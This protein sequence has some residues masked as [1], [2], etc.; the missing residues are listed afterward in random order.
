MRSTAGSP[1]FFYSGIAVS[2]SETK[3]RMPSAHDMPTG[4]TTHRKMFPPHPVR[5]LDFYM[6]STFG[7]SQAINQASRLLIFPK[8]IY[9]SA[10]SSTNWGAGDG[11]RDANNTSGLD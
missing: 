9:V 5:V 3:D 4:T 1:F 8:R 6:Y 11:S 10:A 2:F 7:A